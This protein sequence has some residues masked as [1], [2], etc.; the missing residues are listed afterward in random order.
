MNKYLVKFLSCLIPSKHD[1]RCFRGLFNNDGRLKKEKEDIVRNISSLLSSSDNS[2]ELLAKNL[3]L[4]EIETFSYCNRQC[5][6]CPNSKIDRHTHNEYMDESLYL[7]IINEL[8]AINY[9]GIVTYSR[10]NEP[11]S[12]EIIL[13]R[14][15]QARDKL[16][17]AILYTHTNGD[18]LTKKLMKKLEKTGINIIKIQHYLKKGQIYQKDTILREMENRA[19]KYADR[20]SVQCFDDNYV[21]LKIYN[22]KIDIIYQALNF[23]EFACNRAGSLD[24][25]KDYRRKSACFM[26]FANMYID[27]NGSVMP[28]CNMR[29]D[30][31]KHRP[32]ILGN[33][34]QDSLWN[35]FSNENYVSIRKKLI[36]NDIN[37]SPCST[38][39]FA[40]YF[41]QPTLIGEK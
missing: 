25:K 14:I 22:E 32:F 28:C 3:Y 39:D 9:A 40:E 34:S 11:F 27:Y 13:K 30:V 4:V 37:F 24:I 10:Y 15:K 8:A 7:K 19:K 2:K 35:I 41:V 31:D 33:I 18:F 20:Y 21:E 1:R 36:S 5:W 29:S 6:F 26:P 16:P 38:C 17:N 23:S 12:D